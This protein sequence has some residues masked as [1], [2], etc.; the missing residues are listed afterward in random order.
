MS[1]GRALVRQTAA[2]V[3]RRC[4]RRS[5]GRG[6]G[7]SH[8]GDRPY[9]GSGGWRGRSLVQVLCSGRNSPR[10][11]ITGLHS[12]LT[13]RTPGR[14]I[15]H[16]LPRETNDPEPPVTT[17]RRLT[18]SSAVTRPEAPSVDRLPL[19][20]PHRTAPRPARR[21]SP[22]HRDATLARGQHCGH[23]GGAH[24][25]HSGAAGASERSG[26]RGTTYDA[27]R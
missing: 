25:G 23:R 3:W 22:V 5:A 11:H 27:S 8:L 21:D 2:A 16:L 19:T 26:M 18:V 7:R 17:I 14:S 6:D 10:L 12:D 9:R 15:S 20:T 24:G 1:Y 4:C 13:H